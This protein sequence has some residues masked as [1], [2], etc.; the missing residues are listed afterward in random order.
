MPR[1]TMTKPYDEEDR[2]FRR[3]KRKEKLVRVSDPDKRII[4]RVSVDIETPTSREPVLVLCS[5]LSLF[6]PP[7]SIDV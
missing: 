2:A 7:L 5:R 1:V 3:E 4:C 6:L